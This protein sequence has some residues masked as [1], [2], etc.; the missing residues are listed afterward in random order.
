MSNS[1]YGDDFF[2]NLNQVSLSSARLV[3]PIVMDLLGPQTVLDLGCGQ[4]AWL[5][6]FQEQGVKS[7]RGYDGSYV[8][9]S[10]LLIDANSFSSLDL[11]SGVTINGHYDLAVC[12]EVAEHLA[13]RHSRQLI[14][15]L[16]EAAPAVMFSAAIPG[17]SGTHHV[18]TQFPNYW[19]ELFAERGFAA[20]DPIRPAIRDD[21]RV[22]WWYRQN[23]LLFANASAVAEHPKV[24]LHAL[25]PG[26]P[27]LEW[28]YAGLARSPKYLAR[29][30]P[31]ELARVLRRS[32]SALWSRA[33][34]RLRHA[35][36]TRTSSR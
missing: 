7:I 21:R 28:I 26:S 22:A 20:Y 31:A 17:Q 4:G 23:I 25:P 36:L 18:N 12:L 14:K 1:V 35:P 11:A 10:E 32:L 33:N 5:R 34:G 15:I 3:V 9:R 29:R 13:S 8:D 16:T 24:E 27:E 19:R 6:V 30:L 2:S